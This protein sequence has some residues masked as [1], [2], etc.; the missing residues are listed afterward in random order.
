V[1]SIRAGGAESADIPRSDRERVEGFHHT[2][3][4]MVTQTPNDTVAGVCL[5][6]PQ[7]LALLGP[8]AL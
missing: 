1:G 2:T 5:T 3:M 8:A 6:P 4:T 7:P